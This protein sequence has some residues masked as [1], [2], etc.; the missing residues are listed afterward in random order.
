MATFMKL[1]SGEWGIK[2]GKADKGQAKPGARVSVRTR[3]G[4]IKQVTIKTVVSQGSDYAICAIESDRAPS[5]RGRSYGGRGYGRGYGREDCRKY[6]WDGVVGS[7]S[8]YSSGQYD[9]DS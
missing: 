7:P 1:R 9:E 4:E 2:F 6:G 3:A 8:Y 5:N